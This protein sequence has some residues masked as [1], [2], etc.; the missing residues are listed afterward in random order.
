MWQLQ[1]HIPGEASLIQLHEM[2]SWLV[3]RFK[4]WRSVQN[5]VRNLCVLLWWSAEA[6]KR[7]KMKTIFPRYG[8]PMLK[9][10][11][12]RDRLIF[13]MGIPILV[14]RHLYIE[15]APWT[16]YRRCQNY[17]HRLHRKVL[18]WELLV[19]PMTKL[20]LIQY[21]PRNMHT[22]L[23]CFALLWLCNRS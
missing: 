7:I 9:I 4:R 18:K 12:S 21:I 17:R 3:S 8:I 5:S 20:S 19:Q 15:T 11:Q 1:P 14:S 2:R 16:R 23:L 13:N 10:R 22:V 6:T